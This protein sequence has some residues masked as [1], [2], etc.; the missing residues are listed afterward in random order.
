MK[1]NIQKGK[2]H[3][4]KRQRR[5]V[6]LQK[7]SYAT[8][9][10]CFEVPTIWVSVARLGPWCRWC[11]SFSSFILVLFI[12]NG[13]LRHSTG[14]ATTAHKVQSWVRWFSNFYS[15][16]EVGGLPPHWLRSVWPSAPP[17]ARPAAASEASFAPPAKGARAQTAAP[18]PAP[19][20]KTQTH[21]HTHKVL[22]Q[23]KE[24]PTI[25]G[26]STDSRQVWQI[27]LW[28]YRFIHLRW[29]EWG[30]LL[31]WSLRSDIEDQSKSL[32][33][34]QQKVLHTQ[35]TWN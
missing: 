28:T 24:T 7:C 4:I 25:F 9:M 3:K 21:T 22:R 29:R 14:S 16:T 30:Q 15:D 2:K 23:A 12:S 11:H 35:M 1:A 17:S 20:N 33:M 27:R 19:A 13:A 32:Q 6:F 10:C 5:Q 31:W 26:A 8:L 18:A 34:E